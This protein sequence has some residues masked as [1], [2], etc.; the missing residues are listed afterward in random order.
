MRIVAICS[1]VLTLFI[2]CG[3]HQPADGEKDA[4]KNMVFEPFS[5]VG[6]DVLEPMVLQWR[7]E[8]LK[9]Y[10][11][12]KIEVRG[13]CSE[14]GMTLL[15][16]KKIQLAM[17]SRKLSTEESN[18]GYVAIPVAKD[19]I[20]PVIN[21]DNTNIQILVQKGLSTDKFQSIFNGKTQ[22]WKQLL[23]N[24]S[25]DKIEPYILTDTNGTSVCWAEMLKMTPGEMKG[26]TLINNNAVYTMVAGN[27]NAFGYCSSS[28]LFNLQ[29]N[30]KKPN[31]YIIPMDL[32]N[33]GQA[34]DRELFFDRNDDVYSGLISG[35]I[36]SPP[37]R[38]L[39]IVFK[40]PV[41][42]SI[43]TFLKWVTTYGQ[44]YCKDKGFANISVKQSEGNLK[45]IQ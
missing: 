6:S 18:T 4:N 8:F 32:N 42:E 10:P 12:A 2:S 25:L 13:T 27:K 26:T 16:G 35:R 45:L 24:G 29:T 17:V 31:I 22:T 21:F 19:V 41:N 34:D 5:V 11:N 9:E 37:A 20:L 1:L 3:T 38:E 7:H 36:P 23:G 39:Y 15:K 33:N 43:Y 30:L 28:V 44:N 40:K 14:N